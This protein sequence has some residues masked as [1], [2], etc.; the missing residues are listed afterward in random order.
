MYRVSHNI[1]PTLYF[2]IF[3]DSRAQTAQT[4]YNDIFGDNP[5]EIAKIGRQLKTK[6]DKLKKIVNKKP[7]APAAIAAASTIISDDNCNGCIR[8]NFFKKAS[9]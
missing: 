9:G 8:N 6:H 5:Q 1:G 4:D 7:D 2:V 3:L